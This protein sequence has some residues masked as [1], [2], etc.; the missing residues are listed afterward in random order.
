[1]I[2]R[3]YVQRLSS[4]AYGVICHVETRIIAAW[5]RQTWRFQIPIKTVIVGLNSHNA[6][7]SMK[8]WGVSVVIE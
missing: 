5:S 3:Q 6:A 2:V 1:V 4:K 7:R 8:D